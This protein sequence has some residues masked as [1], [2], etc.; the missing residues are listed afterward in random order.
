MRYLIGLG[1]IFIAFVV[2]KFVR[3]LWANDLSE[4][5]GAPTDYPGGYD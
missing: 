2:W 4:H 1:I 5:S 3:S